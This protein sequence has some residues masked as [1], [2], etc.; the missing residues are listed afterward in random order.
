MLWGSHCGYTRRSTCSQAAAGKFSR[1][2]RLAFTTNSHE[3]RAIRVTP[4]C[5]FGTT[6]AARR[7]ANQ[8]ALHNGRV[9]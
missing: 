4:T 5:L 2:K 8:H 1:M 3:A 9:C 6:L 7:A